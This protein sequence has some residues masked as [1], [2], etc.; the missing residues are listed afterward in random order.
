MRCQREHA[1]ETARAAYDALIVFD[2]I[3]GVTNPNVAEM[4]DDAR[5]EL[6][7]FGCSRGNS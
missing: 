2:N 5:P 1:S 7:T 6:D 3:G 4:S